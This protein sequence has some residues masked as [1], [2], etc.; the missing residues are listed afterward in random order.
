MSFIHYSI[1]P[2]VQPR[3]VAAKMSGKPRLQLLREQRFAE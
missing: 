2:A 3:I 1:E